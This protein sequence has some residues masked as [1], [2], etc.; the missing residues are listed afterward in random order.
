MSSIRS[1]LQERNLST[2]DDTPAYWISP[3]GEILSK[4]S[5]HI[6]AVCDKPSAFGLTKEY[7]LQVFADYSE[8]IGSE[9]NARAKIIKDLILKGWIRIRYTPRND[10]YT[11]ELNSLS[12][13]NKGFLRDWASGLVQANLIKGYSDVRI[14]ELA[15]REKE[16][17]GSIEE[18][19]SYRLFSSAGV[20]EGR[21]IPI[22]SVFDFGLMN[23][24]E[25]EQRSY[26]GLFW[27]SDDYN[28]IEDVRGKIEFT[29]NEIKAR[30]LVKP[31]GEHH[32]HK[33]LDL[34]RPK[35]RVTLR[36]DGKIVI[37]V[38]LKCP[39]S[40]IPLIKT[41]FGLWELEPLIK[42]NRGYHWDSKKI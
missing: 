39:E 33:E 31:I 1:D 23:Q 36:K 4:V 34:R 38:G 19:L 22:S 17:S 9:G 37:N 41:E 35:G 28:K 26:A 5:T 7:V 6:R 40:A 15:D 13:S 12:N 29:N 32:H 27:F 8:P 24:G 42:I 21:L 14:V 11:I 18:L 25:G 16:T 3:E 10:I 30:Q 2:I 20:V